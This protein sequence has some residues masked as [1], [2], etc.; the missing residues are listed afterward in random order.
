MQ[1]FSFFLFSIFPVAIYIYQC[2]QTYQD[3]RWFPALLLSSLL[4]L[5]VGTAETL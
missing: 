3:G 4:A 1:E 5:R 2:K